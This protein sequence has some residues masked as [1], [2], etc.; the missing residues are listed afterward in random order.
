MSHML[1]SP[2]CTEGDGVSLYSKISTFYLFSYIFIFQVFPHKYLVLTS[3]QW[4]SLTVPDWQLTLCKVSNNPRKVCIKNGRYVLCDWT[5]FL[6]CNFWLLVCGK[7]HI[8][9]FILPRRAPI[10][11][12][13]LV[14]TKLCVCHPS[15]SYNLKHCRRIQ[16][17]SC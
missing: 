7:W 5:N 4:L 10:Q 13:I 12:P 16:P 3:Y 9:E 14:L 6:K 8:L 11:G 15:L 2:H 1:E 17:G